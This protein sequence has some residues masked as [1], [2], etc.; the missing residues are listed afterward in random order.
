[1]K[2]IAVVRVRGL[3]SNPPAV[4]KT[5]EC[6]KLS[7]VNSCNLI[8]PTPQTLGMLQVVR[9]HVAFGEVSNE[10]IAALLFKKGKSEKGA[11]KSIG[12]KEVQAMA[13]K[14][15]E[16]ARALSEFGISTPF[17][18]SPPSGGYGE[19][20]SMYPTGALGKRPEMDSLLKSMLRV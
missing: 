6:L 20:K 19:T 1:M 8:S 18:L 2:T 7:R 4:R 11:L 12:E 16:N 5:M 17:F 13:A 14:V 9:E 15:H 3:F 10:T